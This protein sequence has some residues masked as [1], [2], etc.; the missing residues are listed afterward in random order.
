M[1][2]YSSAGAGDAIS[3]NMFENYAL[4]FL[5]TIAG[6][7]P[8]LAGAITA[9]GSVWETVTGAVAGFVSDATQS[10]WGKRKPYLLF[11][12]IPLGICLSLMFTDINAS[13]PVKTFFYL[14]VMILF[15]TSFS[16]FYIPFTTWGSE[17]TQDY[18]DRTRLRGYYQISS[19]IG[20]IIGLV[21]PTVAVDFLM[22]LG[23][24]G[25]QAWQ[26][27][28]T[29]CGLCTTVTILI[30]AIFIK[31]KY[32]SEGKGKREKA[33]TKKQRGNILKEYLR[34][35][36]FKPVAY[37]LGAS[38][39]YLAAYA[40]FC[41]DRI[42]YFTYNMHL[43]AGTISLLLMV[44]VILSAGM[45]P[46]ILF[47]GRWLDKR[48]TY[49]LGMAVTVITFVFF[50]F[51]DLRSIPDVV[52]LFVGFSCGNVCYW[53]LIPTMIYDVCE[54]DQLMNNKERS[55]LLISLQSL[56]ESIANAVGLQLLG[57]ILSIAGFIG[58][59][60]VQ[61]ETAL[62]WTHISLTFIPS[63]FMIL[64]MIFI[65]KYPISKQVYQKT[66]DALN[67][68][69]RGEE[70]DLEKFGRIYR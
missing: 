18:E 69:E 33:Q 16:A 47:A 67:R 54:A 68:R 41:A 13:M 44:L 14:M 48:Q 56:S 17:L 55:G 29:F 26:I 49:L 38:I 50:G 57:I 27:L 63:A 24:S 9:I 21:L 36:S 3:Y 40:F 31:D 6:I 28:G 32:Q 59:V 52:I 53:Q 25:S 7:S 1:L 37:V 43:S 8:A 10:R 34:A 39:T 66:L 23:S 35:L 4:F 20:L 30:P 42:Y 5:T 70:V 64:S 22:R 61:T 65:L 60:T 2:I 19:A 62:R 58:G 12:A 15:A 51:H 45:V 11:S 46:F